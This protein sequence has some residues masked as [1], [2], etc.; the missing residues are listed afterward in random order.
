MHHS[1]ARLRHTVNA[2]VENDRKLYIWDW[3]EMVHID[4]MRPTRPVEYLALLSEI[5]ITVPMRF[6]RHLQ[7]ASEDIGIPS[8]YNRNPSHFR[9][10]RHRELGI[11]KDHYPLKALGH[12]CLGTTSVWI[13]P[14]QAW[15]NI[16]QRL[17]M[18]FHVFQMH[19]LRCTSS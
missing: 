3:V 1:I 18:W 6:S 15:W 9:H 5:I 11:I 13:D 8:S 19:I 2:W 10:I 16:L 7:H 12:T 14:R 17:E 4:S